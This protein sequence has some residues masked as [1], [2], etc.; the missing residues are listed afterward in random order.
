MLYSHLSSLKDCL[1]NS[2][3]SSVIDYLSTLT[4]NSKITASKLKYNTGLDLNTVNK[5]LDV[6]LETKVLKYSFAVQCPECGLLVKSFNEIQ[7]IEKAYTCYH[8][9]TDFEIKENDVIVIYSFYNYPFDQ[10]QQKK[11]NAKDSNFANESVALSIDSLEKYL[12]RTNLDLNKIFYSP[13]DKE[14]NA[15]KK[16]YKSI[17]QTHSSTKEQGDTLEKLTIKLFSL[18]H[19]FNA[20]SIRMRPNQIDCYVRNTLFIP[21]ISKSDCIDSFMIE[22][23]NEKTTPKSGYMNKLHSI[24]SLSGNSFGIIVSKCRAPKTFVQLSNS[25]YL[26]DKIII[27]S[28]DKNDIDSIINKKINLLECIGRKITEVKTNATTDLIKNNL[29]KA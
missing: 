21:G 3:Y 6:L 23:K 2:Q 20:A 9:D 27:I 11:T 28:I 5:V 24:L 1:S 19:H 15:L 12:H 25:I 8:C 26:S 18:C 10:G 14:Y 22:C 17:F 13:S 16:M 4:S 29:Y 7:D